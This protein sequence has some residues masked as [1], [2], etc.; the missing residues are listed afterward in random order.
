M[1][2]CGIDMHI[3]NNTGS[4]SCSQDYHHELRAT[5]ILLLFSKGLL[6][7]AMLCTQQL[8]LQGCI[9]GCITDYKQRDYCHGS[10]RGMD[11]IYPCLWCV[12]NSR[13]HIRN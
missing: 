13:N 5:I 2:M 11:L 3:V 9:L 6:L 10:S 7:R 8:V 12:I 4:E 1:L